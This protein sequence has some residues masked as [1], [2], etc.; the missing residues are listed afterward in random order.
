MNKN[1]RG[2]NRA[3]PNGI[4]YMYLAEDEITAIAEIKGH[5]G[6]DITVAPAAVN[7]IPTPA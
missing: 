7:A 5:V 1:S 4:A 3:S 2:P 6:D